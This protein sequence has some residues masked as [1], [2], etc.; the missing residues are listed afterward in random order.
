MLISIAAVF[1][2]LSSVNRPLEWRRY[3]KQSVISS[4]SFPSLLLEPALSQFRQDLDV[5]LLRRQADLSMQATDFNKTALAFFINL[6][7]ASV[8][9]LNQ[10]NDDVTVV[11]GKVDNASLSFLNPSH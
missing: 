9:E 4:L 11:L 2:P 8:H 1:P 7:V 10:S 6:V 3:T 5:V